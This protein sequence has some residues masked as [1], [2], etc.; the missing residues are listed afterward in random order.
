VTVGDHSGKRLALSLF[1]GEFRDP[2]DEEAYRSATQQEQHQRFQTVVAASVVINTLFGAADAMTV[3]PALLPPLLLLRG[4][5]MVPLLITALWRRPWR[6]RVMLRA[7]LV[8]TLIFLASMISV[9][10]LLPPRPVAMTIWSS[11]ILMLY[12]VLPLSLRGALLCGL[13]ASTAVLLLVPMPWPLDGPEA[14]RALLI[15]IGLNSLGASVHRALG[16]GRRAEFSLLWR[17][18]PRSVIP[19]LQR[20]ERV[21]DHVPSASILFADIVGFSARAARMPV[22][23]VVEMLDQ[24]FAT[25]DELARSFGAE[26]IKTIGDC[27]M[28]A[29]GLPQP[30]PDHA[31]VIARFA[32]AMRRATAA[33]T[34]AGQQIALRIGLHC[35]PV[36]AGIIGEERFLYDVWGETVNTAS[37]MESGGQAGAIVITPALKDALG[38]DFVYEPNPEIAL[39]DGT[40]T[41]SWR[42]LGER[43]PRE[44]ADP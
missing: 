13:G 23:E 26:K 32:L 11:I 18:L 19:R 43:A 16:R 40:R 33:K 9:S 30:R 3:A 27:Y 34:F 12:L 31:A 14:L 28:A 22:A 29:V 36:A 44:R 42:L 8:A 38:D 25:F 6:P 20:G 4:L 5:G 10:A 7:H 37:R 35:G 2:A 17:T 1:T 21:V 39:K 15:L 41:P 24:L